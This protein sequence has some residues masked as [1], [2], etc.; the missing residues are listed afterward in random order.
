MAYH[1][2]HDVSA[3]VRFLSL[4]PRRAAPVEPYLSAVVVSVVA[5]RVGMLSAALELLSLV[6]T[7]VEAHFD[8]RHCALVVAAAGQVREQ[9]RAL[10]DAVVVAVV[11]V[12]DAVVV[13]V[14]AVVDAVVVAVVAVVDVAKR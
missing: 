7:A 9:R 12:V 5:A 4:G 2:V 3:V 14:V 6:G 13:A 1:V 10:V 8:R 11:A